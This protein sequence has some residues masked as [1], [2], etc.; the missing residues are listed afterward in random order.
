MINVPS[1][2]TPH[3]NSN[4]TGNSLDVPTIEITPMSGVEL[5]NG[6]GDALGSVDPDGN[7]TGPELVNVFV[8]TTRGTVITP[9]RSL[10]RKRACRKAACGLPPSRRTKLK[11]KAGRVGQ[12]EPVR[13]CGLM[14][15][16][17]A[18]RLTGWAVAGIVISVESAPL[19]PGIT[20]DATNKTT[21]QYFGE[22][23]RMEH[24]ARLA[25]Q[26]ACYHGSNNP[27]PAMPTNGVES[28]GETIS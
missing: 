15:L 21:R 28:R 27:R 2:R 13:N 11:P 18:V 3:G 5:G 7:G 24:L 25:K 1:G 10:N 20:A 22:R 14:L 23:K 6:M 16:G 17:S 4:D 8:V 26:E 19:H 12:V 9:K